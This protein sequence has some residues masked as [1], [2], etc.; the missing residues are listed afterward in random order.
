MLQGSSGYKQNYS[1][2][3]TKKHQ[4]S[5]M[6]WAN[7]PHCFPSFHAQNDELSVWFI[8]A[9]L[10]CSLLDMGRACRFINPSAWLVTCQVAMHPQVLCCVT[11]PLLV[12]CRLMHSTSCLPTPAQLLQ[13]KTLLSSKPNCKVYSFFIN[14]NQQLQHPSCLWSVASIRLLDARKWIS[15]GV[16]SKM[17]NSPTF[18]QQK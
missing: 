4:I 13:Q 2:A 5:W 12:F 17:L 6:Q 9:L 14:A 8:R 11:R 18:M 16:N 1:R 3:I 10:A 7:Q 15:C